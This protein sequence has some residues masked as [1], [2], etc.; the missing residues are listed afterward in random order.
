[1][2]VDI[3]EE[4]YFKVDSGTVLGSPAD[5]T[6]VPPQDI[7]PEQYEIAL[8]VDR[9]ERATN[10][11]IEKLERS[12]AGLRSFVADDV[13]VVGYDPEVEGLFWCAGQGGYGI[14]TSYGMG[15]TSASL[16]CGLG[17]PD[18]V[19]GVWITEV[20]PRGP[21]YDAGIRVEDVINVIAEVNGEEIETVEDLE[22]VVGEAPP[23][24]RMRL[25]I[26]RFASGREGAPLLAFPAKPQ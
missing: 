5:E 23:G 21:L 18:D 11:K 16:A 12:W 4:F 3:D 24:S 2:V 19:S 9:L 10:M 25:Q 6:P 7:Q 22:R 1:M 17:I 20:S 26:R 8:A 13:P 15:R 14:E